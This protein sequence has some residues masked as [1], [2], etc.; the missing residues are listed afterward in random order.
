VLNILGLR[1]ALVQPKGIESFIGNLADFG[2]RNKHEDSFD[3]GESFAGDAV[4]GR[5]SGLF[6]R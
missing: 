4:Y 6:G 2:H 3:A 5:V 1:L